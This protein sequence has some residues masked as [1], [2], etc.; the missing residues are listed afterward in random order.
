MV[1]PEQPDAT[2]YTA[3]QPRDAEYEQWKEAQRT[4]AKKPSTADAA[5]DPL[6]RTGTAMQTILTPDPATPAAAY[7]AVRDL[8]PQTHAAP[9]PTLDAELEA[10]IHKTPHGDG[11]DRVTSDLLAIMPEQQSRQFLNVADTNIDAPET[12]SLHKEFDTRTWAVQSGIARLDRDVRSTGK[13]A[14][15]VEQTIWEASQVVQSCDAVLRDAQRLKQQRETQACLDVLKEDAERIERRLTAEARPQPP[16]LSSTLGAPSVY[17]THSNT[18]GHSPAQ[19]SLAREASVPSVH[20]PQDFLATTSTSSFAPRTSGHRLE[21]AQNS[22]LHRLQNIVEEG[23][24]GRE[25]F[26]WE[27]S[28][29]APVQRMQARAQQQQQHHSPPAVRLSSETA[30]LTGH[31]RREPSSSSSYHAHAPQLQQQRSVLR[32][33]REA[34]VEVS[35]AEALQQGYVREWSEPAP[36]TQKEIE[37]VRMSSKV[38]RTQTGLSQVSSQTLGG[39]GGAKSL[40]SASGVSRQSSKKS[41][42][43]GV[44]G[45]GARQPL[46]VVRVNST[47]GRSAAGSHASSSLKRQSRRNPDVPLSLQREIDDLDRM[48]TEV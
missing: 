8:S 4:A 38:S 42:S 46:G 18:G 24:S 16:G 32:G 5:L 13:R 48:L 14:D 31:L 29:Q 26:L 40:R 43:A 44:G 34:E 23:A 37:I 12:Y 6:E 9:P 20:S 17:S 28:S 15:T 35:R 47:S 3:K 45:G 1:R 30:P 21:G 7:L 39:R 2:G 36:V 33:A 25:P 41:A 11:P 27:N 19:V 10:I 22:Q